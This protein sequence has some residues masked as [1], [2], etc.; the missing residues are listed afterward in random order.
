MEWFAPLGRL[1]GHGGLRE[2]Y[3]DDCPILSSA[4]VWGK[5]D[6]KKSSADYPRKNAMLSFEDD[7][8]WYIEGT[9]VPYSLRWYH[10]RSGLPRMKMRKQPMTRILLLTDQAGIPC[11]WRVDETGPQTLNDFHLTIKSRNR[12]R[13]I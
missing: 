1:N 6:K 12:A 4:C 3:L 7:V 10:R 5:L 13:E 9:E 11:Q 8:Q 2:L